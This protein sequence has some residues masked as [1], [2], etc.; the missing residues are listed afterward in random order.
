[1][2]KITTFSALFERLLLAPGTKI[3]CPIIS[4]RV[5]KI[6][7]DN[8]YD[9]YSRTCAYGSSMVEVVDFTISYSPVEIIKS[10]RIIMSFLSEECLMIF[11]LDIYNAFQNTI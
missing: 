4:F 11:I 8:Q 2:E 3:L 5:K 6:D 7:I 1:M 10:L 9:L